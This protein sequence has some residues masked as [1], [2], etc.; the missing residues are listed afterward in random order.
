[1]ASCSGVTARLS[2]ASPL[3]FTSSA[4]TL[5]PSASS[6][7]TSTL[8]KPPAAPVTIATLPFNVPPAMRPLRY[9]ARQ[10]PLHEVEAILSPEQL[11]INRVGRCA[12]HLPVD[13][14]LCIRIVRRLSL[15]FLRPQF[16]AVQPCGRCNLVQCRGIRAVALLYPTR[17]HDAV[18]KLHRCIRAALLV[19]SDDHERRGIGRVG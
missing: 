19:G 4:A 10:R 16:G 3:S 17:L 7:R 12:E 1:C 18:G 15:A 9:L 8:P 2:A 14:L 6:A 11:A 5:A 13:R